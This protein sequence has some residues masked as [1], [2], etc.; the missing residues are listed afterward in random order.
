VSL[1]THPINPVLVVHQEG[2]VGLVAVVT[3]SLGAGGPAT[4]LSARGG[5][6]AALLLG[7]GVGAGL[8]VAVWLVGRVPPL[9]QLEAWQRQLVGA[10]PVT[11][12]VA[13]ALVSGIA[14][15]A[16][17]RAALQPVLGLWGAAALFAL[18]HLAPDRRLWAWPV[19]ALVMGVAFG[20]VY[21]RA[22]Y[23]ACAAAHVAVNLVGLLR[24]RGLE[25]GLK[26]G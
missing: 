21:R 18:L 9:S 5:T 8:A 17:F 11:D 13:V 7:V 15:E 1:P 26:R 10:W 16:L 24:L 4:A 25:P 2:V 14:E 20:L 23:P 19:V 22:G 12:A 3:L 6:G